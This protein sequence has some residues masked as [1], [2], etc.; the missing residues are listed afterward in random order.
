[1]PI[2]QSLELCGAYE[3]AKATVQLEVVH[4]GLHGGAIFYDDERLA[5]VKKFLRRHF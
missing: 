5:A 3:K 1:M 2:N 4:G